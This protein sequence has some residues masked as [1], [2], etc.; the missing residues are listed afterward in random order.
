MFD[1]LLCIENTNDNIIEFIYIFIMVCTFR[2]LFKKSFPTFK[3]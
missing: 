1:G 2:V 3:L